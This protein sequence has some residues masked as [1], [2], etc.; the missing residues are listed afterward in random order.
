MP[1]LSSNVKIVLPPVPVPFSGTKVWAALTPL[2]NVIN[3]NFNVI[4]NGAGFIPG[5]VVMVNGRPVNL[6]TGNL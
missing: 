5:T 6:R 4:A 1:A 2:V 3:N